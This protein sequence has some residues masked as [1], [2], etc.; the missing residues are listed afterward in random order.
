MEDLLTAKKIPFK[1]VDV[2]LKENEAEKEAMQQKSGKSTIPQV[3]V[4]GQ[5]RGV[6]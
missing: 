6:T 2:S 4:D 1:S 3:F 5:F